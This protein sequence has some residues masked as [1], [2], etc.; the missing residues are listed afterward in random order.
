MWARYSALT[1]H[2][3]LLTFL[4]CFVALTGP[5]PARAQAIT[6]D[7]NVILGPVA[8]KIP[9]VSVRRLGNR[10]GAI[11]PLSPSPL[12]DVRQCRVEFHSLD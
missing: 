5:S 11:D 9:L 1:R 3:T 6:A 4:L 10:I 12:V 2:L 8:E 7:I